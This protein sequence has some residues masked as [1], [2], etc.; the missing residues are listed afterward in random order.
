MDPHSDA[1]MEPA[2]QT[3]L[4]A[5]SPAGWASPTSREYLQITNSTALQTTPSK[6]QR[7]LKIGMQALRQQNAPQMTSRLPENQPLALLSCK[8][9]LEED[10]SGTRF[11][12]EGWLTH[13]D[14]AAIRTID[15]GGRYN[16]T[17]SPNK[18]DQ[19]PPITK[20]TVWDIR[21]ADETATITC[22]LWDE[23]SCK[24]STAVTQTA[25]RRHGDNIIRKFPGR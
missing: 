2:P 25:Y 10:H 6:H 14:K 11:K 8:N 5:Q 3:P 13:C 4:P 20:R 23:S 12:L 22:T 18:S 1:D 21:V 9:I 15:N 17:R 19:K 7:P 16:N 24:L